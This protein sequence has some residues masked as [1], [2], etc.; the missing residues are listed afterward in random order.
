MNELW[1]CFETTSEEDAGPHGPAPGAPAHTQ[2]PGVAPLGS[3]SLALT[4]A[5]H[6]FWIVSYRKN[7][8]RGKNT[9]E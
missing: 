2:R 4:V 6:N 3:V 7:S 1:T 9:R 5:N 8:G